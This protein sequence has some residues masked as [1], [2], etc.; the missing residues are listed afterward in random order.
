[1]RKTLSAALLCAAIGTTAAT[2]ATPA[3][4]PTLSPLPEIY[5]SVSRPLCSALHTKVAPAIAMMAQNDVTIAKSPPM[6][7]DY[8]TARFNQSDAAQTLTLIHLE[9]LV[10]PLVNNVLAIQKLLDDPSV[11][12]LNPKTDDEKR[13]ADLKAKMLESLAAQQAALDIINGFVD[14]QNMSDMQ[15]QGFGYIAA[16]TG[17]NSPNTKGPTA[18]SAGTLGQASPDPFNRPSMFDDT[19]VNAGLSKNPYEYNLPDIPGLALGYN[20]IG[21]LREGVIWT[22]GESGKSEAQLAK[23]VVA[24]VQLCN[25]QDPTAS[26]KP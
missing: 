15:H 14:T 10:T 11:F 25:G 21:N 18:L 5:H 3:P 2:A 23:T 24:T 13:L 17:T 8:I 1:M 12:S 7:K 22:Q 20:P 19:A 4:A 6:F 16:I 9:S 26:P